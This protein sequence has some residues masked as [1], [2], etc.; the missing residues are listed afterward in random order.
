MLG[1][2]T[3]E[4]VMYIEEEASKSD[5]EA[6]EGILEEVLLVLSLYIQVR[7]S[8]TE[9]GRGHFRQRD[10][11]GQRHGSARQENAPRKL[12]CN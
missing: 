7:I 9:E 8:Q 6:V 5:K 2:E 3:G 12:R 10:Q 4:L 11:P 1:S